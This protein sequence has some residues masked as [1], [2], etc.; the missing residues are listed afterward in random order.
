VDTGSRPP[1]F[2]AFW[3]AVARFLLRLF[4]WAAEGAVPNLPKCV[5]VAAPHTSNWDG[6]I[7]VVASF[8]LRV[9]LLWIGKH[10]LFRPPV[11]WL[12]RAFGGVPINRTTTKNAVEQVAQTFS[13]RE[14]MVLVI[15]P[16]G[17]RKKVKHWRTGFYYIALAS[18]IPLVLGYLDYNRKRAGL[19]PVIYPSGNIEADM[20]QIRAFY[21]PII[22]RHPER[23]S[24]ITL[25][26]TAPEK[27]A[28]DA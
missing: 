4:G 6:L 10:T 19:G 20:E 23:M 13:E 26:P 7:L 16:E 28:A 5:V 27:P 3:T 12:M 24:P 2:N 22:G 9:R 17:T 8:A 11:G 21:A 15:A 18:N 25:A 1:D 14:R